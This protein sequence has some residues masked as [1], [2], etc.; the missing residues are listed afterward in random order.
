VRRASLAAYV[1]AGAGAVAAVTIGLFFWI[2]QPWGTVNDLA[3]LVMT[4]AIAPFM[5]AFWELGGR[6]PTALALAAQAAGWLAVATWCATQ[7]LMIVGA[8]SFD[9]YAPATGAF[10]IGSVALAVIGLWIAG[11]SLLA[12]PWLTTLRWPGV[13][14]GLG[15][16][17]FTFGLLRGGVDTG[18]TYLGGVFYEFGFPIWAFLMG[19][20]LVARLRADP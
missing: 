18:W 1:V 20:Q 9:Y 13:V 15:F 5:L 10:A 17:V 19:R 12:G 11:A 4:A 2:D 7:A 6:T 14:I 16:V 8:V 3:L